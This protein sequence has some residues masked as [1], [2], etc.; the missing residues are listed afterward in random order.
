ME[1]SDCQ[2]FDSVQ[3]DY[4]LA[5]KKLMERYWRPFF[6]MVESTTQDQY[7][8]EDIVQE[9]LINIWRKRKQ[10]TIQLSKKVYLF[11]CGRY[12][13]FNKIQKRKAPEVDPSGG[14]NTVATDLL[15][16]VR[17]LAFSDPAKLVVH[18]TL[19]NIYKERR[20]EFA[21][22]LFSRQDMIRFG[23]FLE[24][25]PGPVGRRAIPATRLLYP[26]PRTSLDANPELDQ[27]PGYQ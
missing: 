18:T 9:V 1:A 5:L 20:F 23:T 16:S 8:S 21:W 14:D 15:N 4:Q 25:I 19:S 3:Q 27:N 24:A 17:K 11:A 12:Q 26:I 22:E 7:A 10:I 6:L 2:L 13:L